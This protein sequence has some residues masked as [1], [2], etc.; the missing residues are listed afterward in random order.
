MKTVIPYMQKNGKGSI[1]NC[2]SIASLRGTTDQ[3][4]PTYCA[5]KGGLRSLNA[6]AAAYYAK[7]NIRVNAV[8]PGSIYTKAVSRS[9]LSFEQFKD[10]FKRVI[11]LP[12]HGG[13][14]IDIAYAY[15][16]LASDE[17]KFISGCDLVVDGAQMTQGVEKRMIDRDR[18][19]E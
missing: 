2:I 9:G 19:V 15:L 5:A 16:F 1:V 4:A 7:D 8:Y 11:P 10:A 12:P 3:G 6:N 14:A 18:L 17:S 13:E